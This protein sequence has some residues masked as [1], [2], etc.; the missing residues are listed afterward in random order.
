M[1][2][3]DNELNVFI[4]EPTS[5]GKNGEQDRDDE[6]HWQEA[7]A[8][9]EK[10][11][12]PRNLAGLTDGGSALTSNLHPGNVQPNSNLGRSRGRAGKKAKR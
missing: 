2:I 5:R 3:D 7:A 8:E 10:E 11:N 4:D 1:T 12:G 6:R 9:I